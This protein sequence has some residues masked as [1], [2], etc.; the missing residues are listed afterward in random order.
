MS[1]HSNK[2]AEEKN[3]YIKELFDSLP[4][5]SDCISGKYKTRARTLHRIFLPIYILNA[6]KDQDSFTT[7][8]FDVIISLT[9]ESESSLVVGFYNLGMSALRSLL[10][11]AIKLLYYE[12]HPIE[13]QLHE[14]SKHELR[15]NEYREFLY[16]YPEAVK[17]DDLNSKN[18]E[19]IWAEL[20]G[21]VHHN[22]KTASKIT[23]I[24]E[25]NSIFN[26]NENSW[27]NTLKNIK[28]V[29]RVVIILV[30]I[31]SPEW[32]KNAEKA[33][34]DE[35]FR[36]FSPKEKKDIRTTFSLI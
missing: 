4:N 11:S 23:M 2:I 30:L 27:Q 36:I 26:L 22:Y 21:F 32:G 17:I 1:L 28:R 18:I 25:L 9:I 8:Y 33:Y 10:E 14:G 31:V 5:K 29:I 16:S 34:Y 3:I 6:F 24:K 7:K 20:C 19:T 35:V 12:C 15:A 13:Y